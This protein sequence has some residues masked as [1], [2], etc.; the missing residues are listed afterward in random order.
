[1]KY[2]AFTGP[3]LKKQGPAGFLTMFGHLKLKELQFNDTI[4]LC[5]GL[6]AFPIVSVMEQRKYSYVLHYQQKNG[7][8]P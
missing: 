1:M 2:R 4:E 5:T 7:R 6:Q 8:C 3:P